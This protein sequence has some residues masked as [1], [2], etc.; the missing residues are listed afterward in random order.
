MKEVQGKIKTHSNF[1]KYLN[2]GLK[3][4]V[5]QVPGSIPII[6]HGHLDTARSN[7]SMLG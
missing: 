4:I 1:Y 2:V 5:Q 7:S 6:S 3:Q